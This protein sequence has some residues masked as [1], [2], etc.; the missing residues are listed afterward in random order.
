[1]R[2]RGCM[3]GRQSTLRC[4]FGGSFIRKCHWIAS[5]GATFHGHKPLK[6]WKRAFRFCSR[7]FCNVLPAVDVCCFCR[8]HWGRGSGT[9]VVSCGRH[10]V[11]LCV[12]CPSSSANLS[13]SSLLPPPP[14]LLHPSLMIPACIPPSHSLCPAWKTYDDCGRSIQ[15]TPL[16]PSRPS[17]LLLAPSDNNKQSVSQIGNEWRRMLMWWCGGSSE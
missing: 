8:R 14:S 9:D 13:T 7:H 5:S 16:P 11:V 3:E 17:C 10:S 2:H 6:N 15:P 4:T 12:L 1:M